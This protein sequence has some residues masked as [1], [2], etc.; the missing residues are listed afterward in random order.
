MYSTHVGEVR[1]LVRKYM[2][3]FNEKNGLDIR[4]DEE[5]LREGYQMEA[6][7]PTKTVV[8]DPHEITKSFNN[9]LFAA[10]AGVSTI[11]NLIKILIAHE[12][13]HILDYEKNSFYFHN[14]GYAEVMEKNAWKIGSSYIEGGLISEYDSFKEFS[15]DSYRRGNKF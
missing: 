10:Q 1:K 15:M 2:K 13:G 3:T 9:Q 6:D 7:A 12:V 11:E 14:D 8:F 5:K 4:I